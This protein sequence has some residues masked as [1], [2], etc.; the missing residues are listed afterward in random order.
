M[1]DILEI[2]EGVEWM[3]AGWIFDRVLRLVEDEPQVAQT[4]L[5][6][7]LREARTTG[8]ADLLALDSAEFVTLWRA[9]ETA[10]AGAALRGA[11]ALEEPRRYQSFMSIFSLLKALLRTDPRAAEAAAG[12]GLVSIN[13]GAEWESPG[14]LHDMVLENLAASLRLTRAGL[15]GLLLA[16]RTYGGSGRADLRALDAESF[17]ALLPVSEWIVI[18]YGEGKGYDAKAPDFFA[19]VAPY[20]ADFNALLHADARGAAHL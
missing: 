18:R 16:A 2:R 17:R 15:A 11:D 7:P 14:W 1:S 9:S 3:P 12:R 19:E 6:E 20:L 13:D 5:A 4:P 8:Y 10:Y